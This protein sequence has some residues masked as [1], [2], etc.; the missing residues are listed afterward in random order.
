MPDE[1]PPVM[2]IAGHH[3]ESLELVPEEGCVLL[4]LSGS[5][6]M[7]GVS[8]RVYPNATLIEMESGAGLGTAGGFH[9]AYFRV[10]LDGKNKITS[11]EAGAIVPPDTQVILRND[12]KGNRE[13]SGRVFG[14]GQM[15]LAVGLNKEGQMV[16][17]AI[18]TQK[19]YAGI[20]LRETE[21]I[22]KEALEWADKLGHLAEDAMRAFDLAGLGGAIRNDPDVSDLLGQLASGEQ[23]TDAM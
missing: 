16:K 5:Q 4:E 1:T 21:H 19:D 14:H 22:R 12:N 17:T 13:I 7:S 3:V 10:A 2:V 23:E 9:L 6:H 18:W 11:Y 8:A 20:C 15:D